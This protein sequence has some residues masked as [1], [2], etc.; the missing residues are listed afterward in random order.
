VVDGRRM[1]DGCHGRVAA[2]QR[3]EPG[4]GRLRRAARRERRE[5]LALLVP[6]VLGA[7]HVERLAA[8]HHVAV[9]AQAL[10]SGFDLHPVAVIYI[11]YLAPA[12]ERFTLRRV[13]AEELH[14]STLVY[15]ARRQAAA[16]D[17]VRRR[18]CCG[19]SHHTGARSPLQLTKPPQNCIR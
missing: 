10:D 7:P 14:L 9:F 16:I 3:R 4:A 12:G 2:R 11:P 5:A 1:V 6:R 19:A 17:V 13:A 18:A 15:R 8:A